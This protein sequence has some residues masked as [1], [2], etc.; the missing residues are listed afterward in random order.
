MWHDFLSLSSSK[1]VAEYNGRTIW[2]S[3]KAGIEFATFATAPQP[4]D[5][6]AKRLSQMKELAR[7]FSCRLS[8]GG[9]GEELRLLPRPIYRYQVDRAD[10][11]DGALFAVVV[12]TRT[13]KAPLTINHKNS[14]GTTH[15][16]VD[17]VL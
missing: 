7:R 5:S 3:Q 15:H 6:T 10:L 11:M 9:D 1:L 8:N 16:G 12:G 2:Q 13:T 4:A 14:T 17:E